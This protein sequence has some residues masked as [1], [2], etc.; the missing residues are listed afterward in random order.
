MTS[1]IRKEIELK[2]DIDWEEKSKT[3][4]ADNTNAYISKSPC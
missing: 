2:R 4:L 1:A 3:L